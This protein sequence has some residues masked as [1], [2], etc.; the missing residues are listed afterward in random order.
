M[1][2]HLMSQCALEDTSQQAP[3]TGIP[4]RPGRGLGKV[5]QKDDHRLGTSLA[6]SE[7]SNIPLPLP[8]LELRS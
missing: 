3:G 2:T 7:G 5:G 8:S 1:V 6:G 4:Q